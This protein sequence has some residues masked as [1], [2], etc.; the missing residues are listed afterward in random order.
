MFNHIQNN[1]F[2]SIVMGRRSVR[3][4]D[5]NIKISKEEIS[6]MISEASLA[7]SSANMTLAY[8]C[9]RYSRRKRKAKTSCEVQYVTE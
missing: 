4:Y 1:D 5:E 6:D 2:A 7:P 3:N 9:G 8:N